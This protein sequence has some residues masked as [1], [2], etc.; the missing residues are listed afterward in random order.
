MLPHQGTIKVALFLEYF[1]LFFTPVFH[2]L[3]S[4]SFKRASPA[5]SLP[6]LPSLL[7]P[8]LCFH[9]LLES[10]HLL[11]PSELCISW[12]QGHCY[13]LLYLQFVFLG[14]RSMDTWHGDLVSVWQVGFDWRMWTLYVDID[15]FSLLLV[16]PLLLFQNVDTQT[17]RC[18]PR[19][20]KVS[21]LFSCGLI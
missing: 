16:V 4:C 9:W 12:K 6:S 1:S 8:W 17:L 21:M 10:D 18:N 13:F 3:K 5:H 15:I 2:S 7:L 11:V 20:G 19:P 14:Y